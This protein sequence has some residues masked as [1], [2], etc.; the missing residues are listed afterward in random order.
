MAKGNQSQG[1]APA[2][3]CNNSTGRVVF[4]DSNSPFYLHNGDHPGLILVSTPL[5]G[6]NYN[7]WSR[8]ISTAFTAKNKLPFIDGSQLRPKSDDLLYESWIRCNSMVISWILNSVSRE[9]ADSLLYISTAYEIWNDLR[10]RFHQSNAPRIFQ[11]KRL[12][13]ELHQGAMDINSYYTKMRTLW[14]EL[15][16][17]QP[18]SVCRCGSMKEWMDYQNQE[19]AMQF[20][21]GLNESYAQIRAQILL[22]DPLP[23]ISKIFS[24]V[25]QEE[26][27]RSI[28]QGV[29][30]KLLDQ[31]LVMNYGAN[32]AAVKGTY[33]PKGIKSDKVT[34]THCHLPNHTV[35]KCYKLHGYPPGHP[36]YK[37]KQSDK[38]SHMIQ[39]Q[40]Q[41][42]GTA[43]VVG[44][45]LKPEHCRQL[46]AFLSSQLQLGN[47][48][49]MA[50]QQPQQ[51]PES[52]TSC[53][54]DTY[55][56]STSHT[57]FPT[58]SWIIDTGATH[59]ICCSLHH[60]VSFKP[61]NSNVTLPNSLNI[62]VTHIGSVMLL[63]EII[64][65]NVLFVP[66]FK[67]NLLSISS[68]TKQI[69]C[70]VSFSSELCQIQVLN[71]ARTI[72][73]GRRVGDLYILNS[74]SSPRMKVCA[75]V[76]SKTQLWHYR[77]GHISLPRL[78]I[79]GDVIQESFSNNEALSAC[80]ICH[81]SKQKRLPFISNNTVVDSCFDLVHIDI[82]GPF[83]PMNVDGF[84]YF[85]T[86]VDDHSRYTW[87]QLLKSKSDVTIIFPAFCRMIRTQFGKSIKAVRS[88]N[89]PE[90]QFSEFF[91][92]EG[93]VSYHSCVERPQQNSIVER[94]HQH[95]LN[96]ALIPC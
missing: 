33:N 91:K 82:W 56:L 88:D 52:S 63:P 87:V 47:G 59:H 71:Q 74:P 4:E 1:Q 45:I 57:A 38:K 3:N 6:N 26:R 72:G 20:L 54:N 7:S 50:L 49:T 34:C 94:K 32:V 30:G 28:H 43:S 40:P 9:I 83:N 75:T 76:H 67:F 81:L 90:L 53:F 85:L 27:Q 41:A 24:L 61:F 95:I 68:L 69:L 62:P 31:P 86:I 73:T 14:D 5:T 80:E 66:Q 42:D 65:Q 92:A 89:A 48:T 39:S 13:A 78:S 23:V 84:K 46:I 16:D 70:S 58:F 79:L 17:F 29:G 25:V 60:F 93:I 35:D 77:L 12:L 18:I 96:V 44:D 2:P 15:K 11:V 64:L 22:M 37:L 21:M 19:C 36:R 51:P 55:S 8:S 10:D